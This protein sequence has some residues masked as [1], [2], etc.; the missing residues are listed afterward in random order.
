M[1]LKE[2]R[3]RDIKGRKCA[4]FRKQGE[5]IK[6]EDADLPTVATE[7]L[8]ITASVGAYEGQDVATFDTLREYFHTKT[9]EDIIMMLEGEI[10]EVMVKVS[11]KIYQKYVIMISNG[12]PL[13]YVQ[14]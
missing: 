7:S 2:K 5:I 1:F 12:K 9:D 10:A 3:N 8:F 11:S 6:R 4:D 13:I 14:I